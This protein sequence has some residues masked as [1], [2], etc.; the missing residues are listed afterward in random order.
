MPQPKAILIVTKMLILRS[1]CGHVGSLGQKQELGSTMQEQVNTK[2]SLK[3]Q[4]ATYTVNMLSFV[5]IVVMFFG[6]IIYGLGQISGLHGLAI[7]FGSFAYI[8]FYAMVDLYYGIYRRK[9]AA[10]S[11]FNANPI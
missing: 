4:S 3:R 10:G 9:L 6:F 5:A 2:G 8:T 11:G 7:G 1:R